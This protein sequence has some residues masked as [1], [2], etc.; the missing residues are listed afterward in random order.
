MLILSLNALL[1]SLLFSH[2][3]IRWSKNFGDLIKFLIGYYKIE[4]FKLVR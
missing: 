2:F 4:V 3:L 1:K